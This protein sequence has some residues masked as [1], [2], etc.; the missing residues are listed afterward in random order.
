MACVSAKLQGRDV[1]SGVSTPAAASQSPCCSRWSPCSGGAQDPRG[2]VP[3]CYPLCTRV[4]ATRESNSQP[5]PAP[6]PPWG[7]QCGTLMA[8]D[9][10]T[11]N[12]PPC[13]RHPLVCTWLENS[14]NSSVRTCS[15]SEGEGGRC[16]LSFQRCW[17]LDTRT[18]YW[19]ET[20]H[21]IGH[22]CILR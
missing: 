1:C 21:R 18:S 12:F 4:S 14:E 9:L 7:L 8:S 15:C 22:A 19:E 10:R 11:Y 2:E 3:S 13:L 16:G 6:S 20:I 17:L 5:L